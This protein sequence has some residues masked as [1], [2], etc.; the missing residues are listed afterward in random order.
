MAGTIRPPATA[1]TSQQIGLAL[2]HVDHLM[3]SLGAKAYEDTTLAH[4]VETQPQLLKTWANSRR[5]TP[6]ANEQRVFAKAVLSLLDVF[7]LIG[8]EVGAPF[9][10]PAVA[11]PVAPPVE[12]L[13]T[14][15]PVQLVQRRGLSVTRVAARN[16]LVP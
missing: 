5:Q 14:L 7:E 13:W 16:P 4:A 1:P 9:R 8:P 15:P 12:Q 11:P 10:P 3:H 2:S 6:L